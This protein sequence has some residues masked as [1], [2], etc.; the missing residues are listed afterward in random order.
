MIAAVLFWKREPLALAY[1][2]STIE[3]T[4]IDQRIA[5]LKE[6]VDIRLPEGDGPFPVVV[7]L[8]GCA[9]PRPEFHH[10]WAD[11]ANKAGYAA[12]ILDS[13]TPRGYTRETALEIIC[14]GKA[15]LGQE[16][17][18][19]IAAAL[20]MV[21]RD[22]RFDASRL[23]LAGW[24]HGAWSAMDYLTFDMTKKAPP[25]FIRWRT[26]L[27]DVDGA[28]LF[29]PYCGVG[30]RSRFAENAQSPKTL[31]LIA[32]EDEIVDAQECIRHLEKRQRS[33]APVEM[34]V[35]ED[36]NHVFDDPSFGPE[37]GDWYDEPSFSDAKARYKAFLETL[38]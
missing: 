15:L 2:A 8:H 26:N 27:P 16:R 28:I 34:V 37:N 38:Q 35:Y 30:T 1:F 24:S 33:G 11:V 21:K 4:T 3:K 5:F 22:Q 32:G 17:A 31:A 10:Q 29:Y 7:Q 36:A 9:G 19:D 12:F 18:G 23:V 20:E 6:H 13:T 14:N 25:G